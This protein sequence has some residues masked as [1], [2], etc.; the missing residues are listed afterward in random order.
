MGHNYEKTRF[1]F[2]FYTAIFCYIE[3]LYQSHVGV[4][5]MYPT[6]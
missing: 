1:P 6:R 5:G 3:I 2:D 4:L